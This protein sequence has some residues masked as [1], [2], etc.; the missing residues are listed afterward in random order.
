MMRD[1]DHLD[2][3]S[4]PELIPLFDALDLLAAAPHDPE[5]R[6]AH[7]QRAA[8]SACDFIDVAPD[9]RWNW[10]RA[11]W[12]RVAAVAAATIAVIA[13]L[14]ADE[15]L[16]DPAQRVVSSVADAVGVEVPDGSAHSDVDNDHDHVDRPD[17][18]AGQSGTSPAT[19]AD[20]GDPGDPGD[21]AIP[22]TPADPG[23][24]AGDSQHAP[25]TTPADPGVPG[26]PA[27]PA[28][29]R[30]SAD[31]PAPSRPG[32]AGAKTSAPSEPEA[33]ATPVAD[34]TVETD[35]EGE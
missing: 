4:N 11:A 6:A 35:V 19:P 22:A 34:E 33:P 9:G 15:R 18:T 29:P 8:A 31:R 20:P 5:L 28:N 32:T 16:P 17:D 12:W 24:E 30:T 25:A 7:I 13:G 27:T 3:D 26:E 23:Q 10:R 2:R 14:G 21:P 1:D